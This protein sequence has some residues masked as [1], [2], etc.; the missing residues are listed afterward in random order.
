MH[1]ILVIESS[2]N[3]KKVYLDFGVYDISK[4]PKIKQECFKLEQKHTKSGKRLYNIDPGYITK[5][6]VVLASFKPRAHRIYL[7][8]KVY[9][10]L[11]LV[12]E[13]NAWKSFKWTFP[14]LLNKDILQ[15]L[16]DIREQ[17]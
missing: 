9:G 14:D 2:R 12:Y 15:F 10:D 3:L 17:L 16:T 8:D 7:G 6:A 5:N 13:N 4:L 11:Q 1:D